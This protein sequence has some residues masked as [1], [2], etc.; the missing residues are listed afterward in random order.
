MS[1]SYDRNKDTMYEYWIKE[2]SS[3]EKRVQEYLSMHADIVM[4]RYGLF[5]EEGDF[6]LWQPF[7]YMD[8]TSRK[9]TFMKQQV[10]VDYTKNTPRHLW[11]RSRFV[12]YLS[13]EWKEYMIR[14]DE[15]IN[16]SYCEV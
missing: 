12:T 8:K 10:K 9:Y 15:C 11:I 5:L 13:N 4:E 14:I 1:V 2:Y 6:E 3:V 16:A 7:C